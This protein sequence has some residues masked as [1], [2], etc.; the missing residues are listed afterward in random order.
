MRIGKTN[1]LSAQPSCVVDLRKSPGFPW[2]TE[3][4][5][6]V[7]G[8]LPPAS[9]LSLTVSARGQI[10]NAAKLHTE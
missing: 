1:C 4:T 9:E 6:I 3:L 5:V 2:L 10:S 8:D 7:P